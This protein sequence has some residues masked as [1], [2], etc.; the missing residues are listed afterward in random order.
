MLVVVFVW[1]FSSNGRAAASHAAGRG[2]DTSNVHFDP[3]PSQS[4][5]LFVP[6]PHPPHLNI[7]TSNTIVVWFLT[8]HT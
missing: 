5:P 8:R 6:P 4:T 3:I 7:I 2:I 1:A